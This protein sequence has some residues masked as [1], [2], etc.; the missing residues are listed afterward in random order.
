MANHDFIPRQTPF[1]CDFLFTT[2]ARPID[3]HTLLEHWLT[4]EPS[5][6]LTLARQESKEDGEAILELQARPIK[7]WSPL[8]RV[9]VRFVPSV[10]GANVHVRLRLQ[11]FW[12]IALLIVSAVFLEAVNLSSLLC[13]EARVCLQYVLP[14]LFVF[15]AVVALAAGTVRLAM[16][17]TAGKIASAL[18]GWRTSE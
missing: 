4:E 2:T 5:L 16:R 15:V 10:A 3:A 12:W 14:L 7:H 1:S 13:E 8:P 18:P 17:T 11:F 9:T 6:N